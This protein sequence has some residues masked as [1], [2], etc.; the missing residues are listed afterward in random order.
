[1]NKEKQT[2]SECTSSNPLS[3]RISISACIV[4]YHKVKSRHS[5]EKKKK[6]EKSYIY[7]HL[8]TF[9]IVFFHDIILSIL[10]NIQN[11]QITFQLILLKTVLM[12]FTILI[13]YTDSECI[14]CCFVCFFALFC[15]V[16]CLLVFFSFQFHPRLPTQSVI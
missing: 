9:C 13:T 12:P 7:I 6:E 5:W 11:I 16:F 1:M 8:N 4:Q 2:T 14:A 15:F 10:H 3:F